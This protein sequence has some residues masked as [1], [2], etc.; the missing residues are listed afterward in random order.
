MPLEETL[1]GTAVVV[2][3]LD[4]IQGHVQSFLERFIIDEG[5]N[6]EVEAKFGTCIDRGTNARVSLPVLNTCGT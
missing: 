3:E 1:F 2:N 6:Y 4:E 5:L